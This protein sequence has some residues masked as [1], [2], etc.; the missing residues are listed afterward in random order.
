MRNETLGDSGT[1]S[2]FTEFGD[3]PSHAHTSADG[4]TIYRVQDLSRRVA[5]V[6]DI[7]DP[8]EIQPPAVPKFKFEQSQCIAFAGAANT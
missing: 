5:L 4:L 8:I 1:N 3:D 6:S 2:L 7:R